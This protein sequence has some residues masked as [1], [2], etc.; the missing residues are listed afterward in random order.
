MRCYIAIKHTQERVSRKNRIFLL[1]LVGTGQGRLGTGDWGFIEVD[2]NKQTT[3]SEQ[4]QPAS[5]H[6]AAENMDWRG[7]RRHNFGTARTTAMVSVARVAASRASATSVE[8]LDSKGAS[9]EQTAGVR[10]GARL[11]GGGGGEDLRRRMS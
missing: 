3:T 7:A 6:E 5:V 2:A 4:E 8:Q 1:P 10:L 11:S 9:R